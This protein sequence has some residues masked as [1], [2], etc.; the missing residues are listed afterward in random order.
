MGQKKKSNRKNIGLFIIFFVLCLLAGFAI[1]K[2]GMLDGL[3]GM[4]FSV[5]LIRLGVFY[6]FFLLSVFIH[7]VAHEAGHMVAAFIRGWKFLSFMVMGVVLSKRGGHFHLSRFSLAGAGGQCLMMPPKGGDTDW[8]IAFYNAG[9][10]LVNLLLTV[11][12]LLLLLLCHDSLSWVTVTFAVVIVLTGVFFILMNGVPHCLA[13]IP[14][15]GMNILKLRKDAFS[16]QIFL[17]TM[18]IMGYLMSDEEDKLNTMPYQC[19]GREIDPTNAIHLMAL[20][21]D[22]SLAMSRMDFEKARAILIRVEP[23]WEEIIP[24]YRNEMTLEKIFL[25]LTAPH[26]KEDVERLLDKSLLKYLKQ[27]SAFRPSALRVQYALARLHES[28]EHKAEKIYQQFQKVC[29]SYYIQGEVKIEERLMEYVR[30][31]SVA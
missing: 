18:Q 8:G 12:S 17:H 30:Q 14:N 7:I 19:D 25:T 2:S 21:A 23:W 31:L 15:D 28:D 13:G 22:L 5:F 3:K 10:V 26:A 20:S 11:L 27:Q 29:R 24:I 16:T 1:G 6:L 4:P 9:G